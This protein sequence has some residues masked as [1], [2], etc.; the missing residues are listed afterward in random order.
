MTTPVTK[1]SVVIGGFK[2]SVS[3]EEPFWQHFRRIA[4]ERGSDIGALVGA[5]ATAPNRNNLSSCI[6]LFV[7][8]ELESRAFPSG[9]AS[10]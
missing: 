9:L 3:L 5:L 2:T 1:C 10:R 7:L 8:A 6:R 4:A